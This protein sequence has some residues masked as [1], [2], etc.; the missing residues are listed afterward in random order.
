M[1]IKLYFDIAVGILI[2]CILGFAG[3]Q[4]DQ[5]KQE[6]AATAA[7]GV[8]LTATQ[9]VLAS[10]QQGVQA[11]NDA[12]HDMGVSLS[13][14]SVHQGVVARRVV[15]M[16]KND[17]KI[18]TWLDGVVPGTGCLLDDTCTDTGAPDPQRSASSPLR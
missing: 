9:G 6:R 2:V 5:A 13:A 4:Y 11:S 14:T 18:G 1:P 3:Y 17:A 16:G 15:T 10:L 7:M 12:I 8:Q